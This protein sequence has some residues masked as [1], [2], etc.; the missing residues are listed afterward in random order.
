MFS[1]ISERAS[2]TGASRGPINS[3]NSR[4]CSWKAM[5]ICGEAGDACLAITVEVSRVVRLTP[6][7]T[8]QTAAKPA[9]ATG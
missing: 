2:A 8:C 7:I 5:K 4:S 1:A 3:D 9:H 6:R